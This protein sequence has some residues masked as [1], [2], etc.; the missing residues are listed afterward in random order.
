MMVWC[1]WFQQSVARSALP[2]PDLR[3]CPAYPPRTRRTTPCPPQPGTVLLRS[4]CKPS[5]RSRRRSGPRRTRPCAARRTCGPAG[6]RCSCLRCRGTSRPSTS[7]TTSA[8]SGPGMRARRCTRRTMRCPRRS[9]PD[10]QRTL[11]TWWR[12]SPSSG[13][14]RI[15]CSAPPRTCDWRP[16][17]RACRRRGRRARASAPGC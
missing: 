16:W 1:V 7:C 10:Q 8:P 6:T 12:R 17:R 11:R 13:P 14:Q 9:V 4:P 15:L 2:A 3:R 5:A